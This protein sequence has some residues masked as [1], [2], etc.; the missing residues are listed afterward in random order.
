M[1]IWKKHQDQ[2]HECG[3]AVMIEVCG[4]D[5]AV[6]NGGAICRPSKIAQVL[7][8]MY[9]GILI[10]RQVLKPHEMKANSAIAFLYLLSLTVNNK[11]LIIFNYS[12]LVIECFKFF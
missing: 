5:I 11:L 7:K 3:K 2:Q 8:P 9:L 4:G 12:F 6:I 1:S 10:L